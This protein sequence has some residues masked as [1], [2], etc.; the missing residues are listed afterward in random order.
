MSWLHLKE[1]LA[2]MM[3]RT[4]RRPK[5]SLLDVVASLQS[6]IGRAMKK[7][8]KDLGRSSETGPRD[9]EHH[10]EIPVGPSCDTRGHPSSTFGQHQQGEEQIISEDQLFG[11]R[12]RVRLVEGEV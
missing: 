3:L 11:F 2:R 1:R 7:F 5:R 6:G 10:A 12:T 4:T 8:V 9:C